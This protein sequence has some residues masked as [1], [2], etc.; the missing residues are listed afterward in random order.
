MFVYNLNSNH[1]ML[2]FLNGNDPRFS[3]P[4]EPDKPDCRYALFFKLP[5]SP[6]AILL[7]FCIAQSKRQV[8]DSLPFCGVFF[9]KH[10]LLLLSD[11]RCD[12]TSRRLGLLPSPV[13]YDYEKE[14]RDKALLCLNSK[15]SAFSL[16]SAK[17]IL[18][19]RSQYIAP[20]HYRRD[21]EKMFLQGVRPESLSPYSLRNLNFSLAWEDIIDY[22]ESPERT[23]ENLAQ[24]Y[25]SNNLSDLAQGF[26]I[27]LYTIQNLETIYRTVTPTS[28]L[29]LQREILNSVPADAKQVSLSLLK[30]G[31]SFEGKIEVSALR[32]T[33]SSYY[34]SYFLDAQ[35][36][37]RFHDI[38]GRYADILPQDV[39]SLRYRGKTF[40][41]KTAMTMG[42]VNERKS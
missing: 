27:N 17:D 20:E 16:E 14:I 3:L 34:N 19:E 24:N 37:Q 15:L 6:S 38:F 33:H 18:G 29:F 4:G 10:S 35:S 23:A 2:D 22:F 39:V 8:Q 9:P 11:Y 5:Y 25:Y 1:P 36:R 41:S 28:P 40:Y 12:L 13:S 30:E 26:L 42:V 31:K 32:A 21:A 7:Y